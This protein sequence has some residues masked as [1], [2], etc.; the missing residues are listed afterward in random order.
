[1]LPG[2]IQAILKSNAEWRRFGRRLRILRHEYS[3]MVQQYTQK[4]LRL[5]QCEVLRIKEKRQGFTI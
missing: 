5:K 4:I 3:S 2:M 1:M